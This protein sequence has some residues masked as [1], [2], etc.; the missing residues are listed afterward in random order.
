[1]MTVIMLLSVGFLTDPLASGRFLPAETEPA[2]AVTVNEPMGNRAGTLIFDDSGITLHDDADPGA[3][4]ILVPYA[5]MESCLLVD[6]RH[7]QYHV[8]DGGPPAPQGFGRALWVLIQRK[9]ESS[10]R[11]YVVRPE[12]SSQFSRAGKR[13]EPHCFTIGD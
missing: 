5:E 1:M 12:D 13:S 9:G 2:V 6:N 8:V 10:R 11:A 3:S 7:G 4:P